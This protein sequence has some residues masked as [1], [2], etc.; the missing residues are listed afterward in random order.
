MYI[1]LKKI[2]TCNNAIKE[3]HL[4]GRP[5]K[6]GWFSSFFGP[7]T[8]NL[9]VTTSAGPAVVFGQPGTSTFETTLGTHVRLVDGTVALTPGLCHLQHDG[10]YV[11]TLAQYQLSYFD[12]T[13]ALWNDG[14]S[15][16]VGTFNPAPTART[17]T[18]PGAPV[19]PPVTPPPVV[20]VQATAT[21][22]T[23]GDLVTGFTITNGGAGYTSAPLVTIGGG[24]G[25]ATATSGIIDGEVTAITLGNPGTG[26][27]TATVTIAAP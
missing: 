22:T 15:T 3:V 13:A 27:V 2:N 12:G 17:D 5:I 19:T 25:T 4:M 8:V 21:A 23:D 18:E 14:S 9:N 6:K 10:K 26:Y 11:R 7:A 20:P 24:D 1:L 16:I